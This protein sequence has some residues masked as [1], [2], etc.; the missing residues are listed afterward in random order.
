MRNKLSNLEY[1]LNLLLW[2][3]YL[4]NIQDCSA[5][6][7]NPKEY[8]SINSKGVRRRRVATPSLIETALKEILFKVLLVLKTCDPES[9][10]K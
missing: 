4:S 7:N 3:F 8:Y 10:L 2:V 9:N 1:F 6:K 5:Y